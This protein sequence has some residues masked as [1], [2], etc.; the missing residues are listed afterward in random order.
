M[1]KM[2]ITIIRT[3]KMP[4]QLQKLKDQFAIQ[5]VSA[6]AHENNC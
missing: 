1:S 3:L 4:E 6:L 5:L 2:T